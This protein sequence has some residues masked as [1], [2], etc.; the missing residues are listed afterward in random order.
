MNLSR[1]KLRQKL[2]IM[3]I[4][5]GG[6]GLLSYILVLAYS[7]YQLSAKFIPENRA[8]REVESRSALLLQNYFRFALTPD[9]VSVDG[10]GAE[11]ILIR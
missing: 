3:L 9:L 5:V 8:L 7:Y 4:S 1:L 6:I 10:F 2:L 11:I